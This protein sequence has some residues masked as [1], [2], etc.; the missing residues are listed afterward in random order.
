M[1]SKPRKPTTVFRYNLCVPGALMPAILRRIA[2][3]KS[4]N[5]SRYVIELICFDLRRLRAHTLT[6][7]LAHKPL[8]VQHATDLAI[9]RHYVAGTKSNREQMDRLIRR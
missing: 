2:E 3:L 9:E 8:N 5:L 4:G 1:A 6:G 7:P